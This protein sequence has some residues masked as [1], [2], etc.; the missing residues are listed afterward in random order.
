VIHDDEVFKAEALRRAQAA[1]ETSHF[2]DSDECRSPD[3]CRVC[4]RCQNPWM[5]CQC[6][7][8]ESEKL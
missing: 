4:H 1:E 8:R 2:D 6:L 5:T 3:T 7:N